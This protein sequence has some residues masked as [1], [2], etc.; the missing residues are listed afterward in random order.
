MQLWICLLKP[1]DLLFGLFSITEMLTD[2]DS[3][4]RDHDCVLFGRL[5]LQLVQFNQ[6]VVLII[7]E[8]VAE[9][10]IEVDFEL[11]KG[12]KTYIGQVCHIAMQRILFVCP[13]SSLPVMTH[14]EVLQGDI[15]RIE[16]TWIAAGCPTG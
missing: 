8:H 13:S 2:D 12:A 9:E 4:D 16:P 5:S 6:A 15:A 10:H 1:A 3:E 11:V 7:H 14:S